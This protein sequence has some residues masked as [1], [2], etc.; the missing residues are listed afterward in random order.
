[1]EN[2]IEPS[3]VLPASTAGQGCKGGQI[4]DLIIADVE[5]QLMDKIQKNPVNQW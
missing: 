2:V 4:S 1:M 5:Q 3:F